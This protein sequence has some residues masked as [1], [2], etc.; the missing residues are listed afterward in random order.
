MLSYPLVLA[1]VA[2]A[3]F[4]K[5]GGSGNEKLGWFALSIAVSCAIMWLGGGF[6]ILVLGQAGLFVGITVFR[7]INDKT[8]GG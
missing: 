3:F 4:Y 8:Q 7:T 6:L 1:C 5:A 2:A